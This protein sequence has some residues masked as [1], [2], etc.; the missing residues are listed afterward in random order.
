MTQQLVGAY[1]KIPGAADFVSVGASP[2]SH[3]YSQ[4]LEHENDLLSQKGRMLPADPVRFLFRDAAGHGVI[5]GAM[6]PSSD[7]VG[8]RFPLSVFA[9]V[10]QQAATQQFSWLPAAYAPFLDRAAAMVSKAATLT[11]DSLQVGLD[12]LALPEPAEV[13]EA[14]VWTQQALEATSGA[15][16]L[17]RLFGPVENGVHYHGFNM[18][19]TACGR[20]RGLHP[21]TASIVLE[22]PAVDDVQLGFWLT[23]AHSVLGWSTG[24]PSFH[25]TDVRSA[26]HR[27][28][29]SLGA[30][31]AGILQFL[32]DPT[33]A[34]DRLWP[35][36]TQSKA[37]IDAGRRALQPHHLR[38]LDPPAPTAAALLSALIR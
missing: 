6:A 9:H 25:W 28:L 12:A 22:C 8:R 16:I 14:R 33:A 38:V 1:G 17:E 10:D 36:R 31:P 30:P 35:M 34:A 37:S 15:T 5:I 7:Q 21:G 32:A 29:I 2:A 3:A 27:L 23:F 18:F 13:E 11:R 20:V 4:W 19:L 26:D 24:P